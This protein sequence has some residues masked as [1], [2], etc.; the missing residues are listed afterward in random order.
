MVVM[1][2]AWGEHTPDIKGIEWECC[3][4]R[5]L[6]PQAFPKGVFLKSKKNIQ[7]AVNII[8][9]ITIYYRVVFL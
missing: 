4:C 8:C 1:A 6:S 5:G 3:I 2:V 7:P 9:W